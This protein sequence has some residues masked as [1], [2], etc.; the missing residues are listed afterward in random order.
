MAARQSNGFE[1]VAIALVVRRGDGSLMIMGSRSLC[2]A[3]LET[4]IELR[5]SSYSIEAECYDLTIQ[6]AT[7][8]FCPTQIERRGIYL[9]DMSFR[10]LPSPEGA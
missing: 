3:E 9:P 4:R 1:P 8:A 2:K 7:P 10:A 5:G 6:L